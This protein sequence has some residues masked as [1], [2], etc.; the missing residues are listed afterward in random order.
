MKPMPTSRRHIYV[1]GPMQGIAEFNFPRFN[2]VTAAFRAAGHVVFNPAEKDIERHAGT[3]IAT[4]NT[5]GDIKQ[6]KAEHGFSLRKALADD[7][8]FICEQADII[9]MLPGWELSKGANAE[10]RLGIAL[11]SEGVEFIYLSPAE[12]EA[13]EEHY[14]L[15]QA[16]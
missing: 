16:A 14:A 9:V 7:C 15:I 3:N 6:A 5:A 4:G 2:A 12:C 11:Q 1:A 10:H 8:K 13:M